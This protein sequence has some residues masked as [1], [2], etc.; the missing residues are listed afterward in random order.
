MCVSPVEN[1]R[2]GWIQKTFRCSASCVLCIRAADRDFFLIGE[3]RSV[4]MSQ[5][6]PG[7]LPHVFYCAVKLNPV[8][9][10]WNAGLQTRNVLECCRVV[11][12]IKIFTLGTWLQNI[13]S[14]QRVFVCSKTR[15]SNKVCCSK[16]YYLKIKSKQKQP[17]LNCSLSEWFGWADASLSCEAC[18]FLF[19]S[20]QLKNGEENIVQSSW[21][22]QPKHQ[23][24]N[25]FFYTTT[26]IL[27]FEFNLASN[28]DP[29]SDWVI[30]LFCSLSICCCC[31]FFVFFSED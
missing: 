17:K 3:D 15:H 13:D 2:W 1:N 26:I 11:G 12:V 21:F 30:A 25:L 29:R 4:S 28:L 24:P 7:N 22:L 16:E 18:S 20:N 23:T 6:I 27:T 31:C 14:L 5:S 9:S 8:S 19:H 10:P